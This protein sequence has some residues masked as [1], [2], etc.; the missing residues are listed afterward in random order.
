[1]RIDI[2]P[3]FVSIKVPAN[4]GTRKGNLWSNSGTLLGTADFSNGLFGMATQV[5]FSEPCSC[6]GKYLRTSDP[7]FAPVGHYSG[8][9]QF[10]ATAGVDTPP[11][12]ALQDGIAGSNGIYVYSQTSAFPTATFNAANY[13]VDVIYIPTTTYSAMGSVTGGWSRCHSQL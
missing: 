5:M 7:H 12:H 11:L 13:W 4:T 3:G 6:G 1:M 9:S 8:D 10:F 2:L